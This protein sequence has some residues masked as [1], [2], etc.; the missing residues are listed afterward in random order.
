[1]GT[2]GP[3]DEFRA[4]TLDVSKET[5]APRPCA[6]SQRNTQNPSPASAKL[7]RDEPL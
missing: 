1:L 3:E 7:C 5:F 2:Q 4:P 6:W